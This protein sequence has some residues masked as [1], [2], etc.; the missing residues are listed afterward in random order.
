MTAGAVARL[1]PALDK[2]IADAVRAAV[3][4]LPP[5]LEKGISA[6]VHQFR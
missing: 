5:Q 2:A 1:G 4:K 6:K 3:D